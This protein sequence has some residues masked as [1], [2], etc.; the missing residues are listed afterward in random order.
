MNL[1]NLSIQYVM[2]TYWKGIITIIIIIK[3]LILTR[4]GFAFPNRLVE[5]L[6][7]L[8]KIPPTERMSH[9]YKVI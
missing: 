7:T 6:L 4:E 9:K 5:V 8:Q 1:D 2:Y 3:K